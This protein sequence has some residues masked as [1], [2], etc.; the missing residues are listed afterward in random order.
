MPDPPAGP[1]RRHRTSGLPALRRP[2]QRLVPDELPKL[3]IK[4]PANR[5]LMVAGAAA[6][7]PR[8]CHERSQDALPS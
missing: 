7:A 6:A 3:G 1:N 2:T 4:E 5:T 8:L